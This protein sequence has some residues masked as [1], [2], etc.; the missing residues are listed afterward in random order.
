[1]MPLGGAVTPTRVDQTIIRG[2]RCQGPILGISGPFK[3]RWG[4]FW[5]RG[6][7]CASGRRGPRKP[8]SRNPRISLH[9]AAASHEGEGCFERARCAGASGDPLAKTSE[10]SYERP[11]DVPQH[12]VAQERAEIHRRS[13][14]A[15]AKRAPGCK[16]LPSASL[17]RTLV[18]EPASTGEAG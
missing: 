6:S 16:G 9:R 15:S 14:L 8:L 17:P 3:P 1:M 11:K 2:Y 10:L 18:H 13:R 4:G 7:L 12:P 5:G